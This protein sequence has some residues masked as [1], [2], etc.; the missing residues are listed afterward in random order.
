MIQINIYQFR[1]QSTRALNLYLHLSMIKRN[2][3]YT[4]HDRINKKNCSNLSKNYRKSICYHLAHLENFSREISHTKGYKNIELSICMKYSN[5]CFEK[6]LE[7]HDE[8][9]NR[10]S[11]QH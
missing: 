2:I 3:L 9:H 1:L 11:E 5:V 4:I 7:M 10:I 6:N 8:I